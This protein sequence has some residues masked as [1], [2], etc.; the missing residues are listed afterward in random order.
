MS[1]E[2][3]PA[4]LRYHHEHDWVRADCDEAVFGMPAPEGPAADDVGT[5]YGHYRVATTYPEL[6]EFYA[7]ELTGFC[8]ARSYKVLGAPEPRSRVLGRA[9]SEV[10]PCQPKG[11]PPWICQP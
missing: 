3:Y 4:E 10:A 8:P 2:S 11:W 6:V 5:H 1:E 7:A 9:S